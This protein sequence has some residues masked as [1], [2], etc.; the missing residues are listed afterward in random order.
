MALSMASG[1]E[2]PDV[3]VSDVLNYID[4]QLIEL[5]LKQ[6]NLPLARM[7]LKNAVK[8]DYVE[9]NMVNVRNR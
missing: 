5:A 4:T 9:P 1:D 2:I 6:K 8:P 3:S 7:R